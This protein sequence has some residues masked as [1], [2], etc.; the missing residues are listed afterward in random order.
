MGLD[1]LPAIDVQLEQ[2]GTETVI[3]QATVRQVL[4][5]RIPAWKVMD[6]RMNLFWPE[7]RAP[8]FGRRG[9]QRLRDQRRPASRARS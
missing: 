1:N 2:A 5:D 9:L 4:D 3:R 7:W 6:G 8:T